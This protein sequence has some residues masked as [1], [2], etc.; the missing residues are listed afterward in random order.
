MVL[1]G[2]ASRRM[3]RAKAALPAGATTLARRTGALLVGLA[4]PVVEVGPGHTGLPAVADSFPGSGSGRPQRPPAGPLA[5][6]ATG[7]AWLAAHGWSGPV[8]V[9]AT[10]LPLLNAEMLAWLADHPAAGTV[11][12]LDAGG[13]PQPLCARYDPR[14]LT[15]AE[16]LVA[17]GHRAMRDLLDDIQLRSPG[18]ITYAPSS[19]WSAVAGARVLTD[20][21]TPAD[22]AAISR[23]LP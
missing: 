4:Q 2:G 12:P 9:V 15:T 16:L 13:R 10:D 20:V 21:D 19:A 1:T 18:A 7:A 17:G 3:G 11:V 14:E 5:A 23:G 8:L 22:L 6:M